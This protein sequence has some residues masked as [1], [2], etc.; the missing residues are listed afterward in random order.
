LETYISSSNNIIN[1][2]IKQIIFIQCEGILLFMEILYVAIT[3]KEGF[4]PENLPLWSKGDGIVRISD[5]TLLGVA[6]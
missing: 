6:L 4:P 1:P 2:R 5:P 3:L